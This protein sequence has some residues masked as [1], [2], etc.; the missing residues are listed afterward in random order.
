MPFADNVIAF[1]RKC[2]TSLSTALSS[3]GGMAMAAT[4][5]AEIIQYYGYL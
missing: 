1:E 5:P 2:V 3:P 4:L